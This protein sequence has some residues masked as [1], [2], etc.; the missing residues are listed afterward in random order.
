MLFRIGQNAVKVKGNL[1]AF[2]L[3]LYLNSSQSR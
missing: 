1:V 2:A 3:L